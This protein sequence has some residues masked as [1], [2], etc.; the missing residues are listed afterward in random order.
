MLRGAFVYCDPPYV[1]ETRECDHDY[2]HG[3]AIQDHVECIWMN[4]DPEEADHLF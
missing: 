1:M 3:F 4:Y 2:D